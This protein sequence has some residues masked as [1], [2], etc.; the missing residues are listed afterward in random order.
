MVYATDNVFAQILEGKMPAH[1]VFENDQTLAFLDIMPVSVGHT[2]IIPKAEAENIF[3]LKNELGSEVFITTKKV[4]HA[5]RASLEPT[6][7][8]LTQLNGSDAGQT[9]FHY[10]MHIIPVYKKTPTTMHSKKVEDFEKLAKTAKL[11]K[12]AIVD[13]ETD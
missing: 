6:G 10:H 12:Q 11:I 9:V 5:I 1:K 13:T 8:I 7:L 3:E 4:A 2:L